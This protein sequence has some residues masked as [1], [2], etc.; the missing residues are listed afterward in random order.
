[1]KEK[2][3]DWKEGDE[4]ID[5]GEAE[6]SDFECEDVGEIPDFCVGGFEQVCENLLS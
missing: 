6:I 5:L 2:I 3:R 1:M 4:D